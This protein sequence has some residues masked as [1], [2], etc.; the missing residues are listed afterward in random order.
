MAFEEFQNIIWP[1]LF[2]SSVLAAIFASL[3]VYNLNRQTHEK[4]RY[5]QKILVR[6]FSLIAVGS[7]LWVISII[8]WSIIYTQ[9]VGFFRVSLV[10]F[11]CITGCIIIISGFL[12]C[13]LKFYKKSSE[14]R[15]IITT[16]AVIIIISAVIIYYIEIYLILPQISD[17]GLLEKTV[18]MLYPILTTS[19]F[20]S[21]IIVFFLFKEGTVKIPLLLIAI[22]MLFLVFGDL[23]YYQYFWTESYGLVGVLSDIFYLSACI[24][25]AVAFYLLF[26]KSIPGKV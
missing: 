21:S 23:F 25:N 13:W 6:V 22:G 10:D 24:F 4:K 19:M 9:S 16:M 20:I 7:I 8:L 18:S 12:Y 17:F 3:V 11:F 15:Q 14:K 5:M 2:L 1:A 26:R